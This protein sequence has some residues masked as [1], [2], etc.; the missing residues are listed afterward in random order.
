MTITKNP[1]HILSMLS[2][3]DSSTIGTKVINRQGFFKHLDRAIT[4][5]LIPNVNS[6]VLD[7][8]VDARS[9]VSPG[10]G[11]RHHADGTI[12]PPSCY[13]L[14]EYR[15]RVEP[16]L[17][18]EFA[19]TIPG[20]NPTALLYTREA[21]LDDKDIKADPEEWQQIHDSDAGLVLGAIWYGQAARSAY[22]FVAGLSGHNEQMM[23]WDL[24][25]IHKEAPNTKDYE[26]NWAT[27]AD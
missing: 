14:R 20:Q 8:G 12:L 10:S 24:A 2:A 6:M 9:C 18:R 3:F 1:V 7:L 16:F 26:D 25:T 4:E 13:V 21:A 22:R 15:G 23:G 11:K 17:R 27:V 5:Q 19:H